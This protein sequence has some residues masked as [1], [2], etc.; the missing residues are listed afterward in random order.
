MAER[1]FNLQGETDP[2]LT[3]VAQGYSNN[4]FVGKYIFPGVSVSKETGKTPE[5]GKEH[6]RMHDSVRA[7]HAQPKQFSS[8]EIA[9][10]EYKLSEHVL[11]FPIDWRESEASKEIMELET[12]A[13]RAL[14]ESL[15]LEKEYEISSLVQN[16]SLF[17]ASHTDDLSGTNE[18][19]DDP[20]SDPIVQLRDA[21]ETVRH[22]NIKKPNTL[23]LGASSFAA[24]QDH[25]K[26]LSRIINTQLGVV[27][28]D[29]LS[30]LLSTKTEPVSVYVGAGVYVDPATNNNV[31]LWGDTALLAYVPRTEKSQRSR[32]EPSFGYTFSM[33]GLPAVR[34]SFDRTGLI[35]YI[36]ASMMYEAKMLNSDAGFLLSDTIS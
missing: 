34:T 5:F 3:Q 2:I 20:D 30:N 7:I 8:D 36:M 1:I 25:P 23:L 11:E 13:A 18:K 24:L 29:L 12:Y 15:M 4:A 35:K 17:E 26:M 16:S 28:E 31:D 21:I 27:T 14:M 33:S 22:D 32:F 19:W 6:L 10:T 9:F